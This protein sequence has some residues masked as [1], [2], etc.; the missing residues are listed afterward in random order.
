MSIMAAEGKSERVSELDVNGHRVT[1]VDKMDFGTS[2]SGS[3]SSSGGVARRTERSGNAT[4]S[5]IRTRE[6]L[7]VLVSEEAAPPPQAAA[8]DGEVVEV[9]DGEGGLQGEG[10]PVLEVEALEEEE[11]EKLLGGGGAEA[12]AGAVGAALS[13]GGGERAKGGG[14]GGRKVRVKR[15]QR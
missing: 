15:R 12:A 1:L 6:G 10:E 13:G 11:L 2:S 4:V 7:R 8:E 9:G 14:A 5:E 3:G